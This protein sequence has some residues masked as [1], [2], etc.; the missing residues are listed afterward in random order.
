MNILKAIREKKAFKVVALYLAFSLLA[1]MLAPLQVFALTS[2]PAQEE[3]AS[4]EPVSTSDMVDVYSG[5]FTYNIPLLSVPGP[6]GGYPINLA[7]HSGVGMEQEAS[8]VGL[9][10]NVNVGAINR[11]LRGLPDD[12]N[13]DDVVQTTR[14]KQ[15][16]TVGMDLRTEIDKNFGVPVPNSNPPAFSWQVY[17][18]RY[19]GVGVRANL[20]PKK[21]SLGPIGVGLSFDSQNGVGVEPKLSLEHSFFGATVNYALGASINSRQGLQSTSFAM[22]WNKEWHGNKDGGIGLGGDSRLS[23]SFTQSVPQVSAST[24]NRTFPFTVANGHVPLA[25][26]S[27]YAETPNAWTGFVNYSSMQNDGITTSDSYGYLYDRAAGGEDMRDFQRDNIPYSKKVPNLAPSSFTHDLYSQTAQGAG[28]QFRPYSNEVPILSDAAVS[29]KDREYDFTL[30]Y[31]NTANLYHIGAGF[32]LGSGAVRSGD[33][34][35]TDDVNSDLAF[36]D[37]LDSYVNLN[38]GNDPAYESVNFRVY[39]EKTGELLSDDFIAQWGGEE[40]VRAALTKQDD[41]GGWLNR[42][43]RAEN[44]F[45]RYSGDASPI[46]ASSTTNSYKKRKRRAANIEYLR[47]YEADDYGITRNTGYFSSSGGGNTYWNNTVKTFP[48]SGDKLNHLSEVSVL[49]PDGMRYVYGLPAYNNTQVDASFA[50]PTGNNFNSATVSVPANGQDID[51]SGTYDE[52]LNQ[53]ELPAYVHSWLLTAVVSADYVDLTDNGPSDDDLGYWVRF[54]YVKKSSNFQWRVPYEGTSYMHG[55]IGNLNDDRGSVTKGDKE[56]YYLESIET[57]TH[58]AVF[59]LSQREDAVAAKTDIQG[60][61][62]SSP[63]SS[64]RMYK[65]DKVQLYSKREFYKD[66][67]ARSLRTQ[68]VALQTVHFRY[69]YDLC[70]NVPNNT[71]APVDE[72]GATVTAGSSADVNTRKGKLTLKKLYFTNETSTRGELSPYEF[73][74]GT[75]GSISSPSADNPLYNPLNIDR[76]GNYKNNDTY[77]STAYP[78]VDRP[79]TP[80]DAA[81]SAGIWSLRQ[82]KLPSGGTLNVEYESDDYAYVENKKAMHMY[83]IVAYDDPSSCVMSRSGS[84]TSVDIHNPTNTSTSPDGYRFYF[85]LDAPVPNTAT[86]NDFKEQFLDNGGITKVYFKAMM[87]LKT[88]GNHYDE[89]AGYAEI[90]YASGD[91]NFDYSNGP[92]SNFDIGYIT[93]KGED[94]SETNSMTLNPIV[95]AAIQHLHY[96]RPEIAFTPLP[97]TNNPLNQLFNFIASVPGMANDIAAQVADY[98]VW[99]NLKHFGRKMQLNGRSIL[100]LCDYDGRMYGGGAR[101]KSLKLSGAWVNGSNTDNFEYGQEYSYT[102]E[103]N[104]SSGVAYEPHTGGEESALRNPVNYVNSTPMVGNEHLFVETPLMQNYYPGPSVGYRRIVVKS[105]APAKALS[106]DASNSLLHSAAPIMV[107]EFYTPKDFPVIFDQTDLSSDPSIIRPIMIPGIYSSYKKRMARSQ[108]YS[109]IINDM[110]GK[111]KSVSQLTRPGTGAPGQ[112]LISKQEFVYETKQPY[113][114]DVTNELSNKVQVMVPQNDLNGV[115]VPYFQTAV[116][117]ESHD[118]HIDVMENREASKS[119]GGMVNLELSTSPLLAFVMPL[120]NI[121]KHQAS[122]RTVVTNKIIYRTGILKEVVTQTG[123]SIIRTQNLAYD[124]ETGQPVLTKVTNEFKDDIFNFSYP[125]HWYYAAMEGAYKNSRVAVSKGASSP[126]PVGANGRIDINSYIPAAKTSKDYFAV[127]DEVWVD[128]NAGGTDA[129]YTVVKVGEAS[130]GAVQFI[131]LV[132]VNG[133]LISNSGSPNLNSIS[134]IRSGRRNQLTAVAG[135]LALHE[136]SSGGVGNFVAYDPNTGSTEKISPVQL[137]TS[138]TPTDVLNAAAL[139]YSDIW[140]A[141]CAGC[142]EGGLE[143][144]DVINPYRHGVRGLWRPLRSYAYNTSR[145]QND[146]IR[147]DGIFA[148]FSPFN[149]KDPS[150]NSAKWISS[151]TITKYSPYSFE[152]EN[153]DAIGNYSA[154]LYEYDNSLVTAVAANARHKEI[155]FDAFEDY[156]YPMECRSF[157]H[158]GLLSSIDTTTDEHHTGDYSLVLVDNDQSSITRMIWSKN[159]DTYADDKR[160]EAIV[161]S[162]PSEAFGMD[163]CDCLGRFSPIPDKKYVLSAWVKQVSSLGPVTSYSSPQIQ[164]KISNASSTQIALY[165]FSASGKIIE[166]WQRVFESFDLPAGAV[167]VEVLMKNQSSPAS[168]DY[169]DDIRIHPFDAN[170]ITYVYD[171]VSLKLVAELDANNYATYYIYDSEGKLSKVKKETVEGIKT[172]KEGRSSNVKQ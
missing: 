138:N 95:K 42:Y 22:G 21:T 158:W 27:F 11:Q 124:V 109:V 139:E 13:G 112:T 132:D 135:S 118:I 44:Q 20:S 1:E 113:H 63:A 164:V 45:I 106:E 14:I 67:V 123:E 102:M 87:D 38:P 148:D 69:T 120:P 131:D 116:V 149:W 3:F 5:D 152:L 86:A 80:Q 81:P 24:I 41:K 30:E 59:T 16:W 2:G 146:N 23:F 143:P 115:P 33:W 94:A 7:Y 43:F 35:P 105:T 121:A 48:S 111:P 110:A 90:S 58:I 161:E 108:G 53:T 36:E 136:N 66:L 104:T 160:A 32:N 82:I 155:A 127:G 89:V 147:E 71:G 101:V 15:D 122:L 28:A 76:W 166:G 61:R 40:A 25:F 165:T 172:I 84:P 64:E 19:R 153:K 141:P 52:F 130:S 56:E 34:Y 57:K 107:Y 91:Y 46:S 6:N 9:G 168:T 157:D 163:T 12:F 137:W 17:Y 8:W 142:E 159:C 125:A 171:P 37:E 65:L 134:V 72:N 77:A 55:G 83:D 47:S 128:F 26:G 145:T 100:R 75:P 162:D 133:V 73:L 154:A 167:Y 74:Y 4:F 93:L 96:N 54:N 79:Y 88:Q 151:S 10:W 49:Q 98:N 97:Q 51:P 126:I 68:P 50:V 150:Q 62:P 99:A 114:P 169:F 92:S 85:K 129:R 39:G 18:N 31:G 156:A 117:G 144:A 103:D 170:M 119:R 70:P 78:F 29:S 140:Q 60:G